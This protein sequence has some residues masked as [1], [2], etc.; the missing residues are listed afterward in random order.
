[1]AQ[2]PPSR[3]RERRGRVL[4]FEGL[5]ARAVAAPCSLIVFLTSLAAQAFHYVYAV[6]Y[7][8]AYRATYA[9]LLKICPLSGSRT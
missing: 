7:A 9:E 5:E 6:L 8:P 2:P 3:T 4:V 1:M